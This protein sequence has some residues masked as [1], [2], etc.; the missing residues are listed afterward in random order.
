MY[1]TT[2]ETATEMKTPQALES[3]A[4]IVSSATWADAS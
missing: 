2:A 4:P 1:P 3:R